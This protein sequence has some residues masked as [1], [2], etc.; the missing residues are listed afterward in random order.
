M[1]KGFIT[2]SDCQL[3]YTGF[4]YTSQTAVMDCMCKHFWNAFMPY[5]HLALMSVF[6]FFGVCF[7]VWV[8]WSARKAEMFIMYIEQML[9]Q[10]KK[11]VHVSSFWEG[12][13]KILFT[14]FFAQIILFSYLLFSLSSPLLS[15]SLLLPHLLLARTPVKETTGIIWTKTGSLAWPIRG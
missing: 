13:E 4:R 5:L 9:K 3:Y 7:I 10:T 11:H 14:I 15:D 8:L 2:P 6:H 12:N 1:V